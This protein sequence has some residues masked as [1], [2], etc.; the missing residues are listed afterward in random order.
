MKGKKTCVDNNVSKLNWII[1]FLNRSDFLKYSRPNLSLLLDMHVLLFS[2]WPMIKK[3]KK[4]LD[5]THFKIFKYVFFSYL[6][7]YKGGNMLGDLSRVRP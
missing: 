6:K 4:K 2:T 3:K 5:L 7:A 1:F